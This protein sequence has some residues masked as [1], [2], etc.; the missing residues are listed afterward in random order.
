M[1]CRAVIFDLFGTLVPAFSS[2]PYERALAEMV[3]AVG[4]EPAAFARMWLHDTAD[5]RMTGRFPGIEAE[6]EHI[7][8]A[9]GAAPTPAQLASAA[10]VRM[11]FYRAALTPRPDA[12]ATLRALKGLGLRLG[13]ISDCSCEAPALWPST[14][15]AGLIEAPVF[16]CV[17]GVRKPHP[18]LFHLACDGLAVAPPE[19]AYV[20]DGYH[21]ELAAARS[22]GMQAVLIDVP[23]E[24]T[25]VFAPDEAAG[26]AG[27][28]VAALSE[29]VPLLGDAQRRN[30]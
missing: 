2:G 23:G 29:L 18:R 3:A 19:C 24:A 17:A 6:V 22:L 28:R 5:A 11:A 15:F 30:A 27:A 14:P 26:W 4:V 8:R 13:L 16:S 9:L 25:G 20:A 1:G 7:A 12:V 10:Q 21:G